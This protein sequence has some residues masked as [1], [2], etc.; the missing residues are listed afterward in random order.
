[1]TRATDTI[2]TWHHPHHIATHHTSYGTRYEFKPFTGDEPEPRIPD[3]VEAA[4]MAARDAHPYDSDTG[5]AVS[6]SSRAAYAEERAANTMWQ[7]ARHNR[8][9]IALIKQVAPLLA[10]MQQAKQAA[11]A[12]Y[13]ALHA[14]P[15]GFWQA[16]LLTITQLRKAALRAARQ[17]DAV[18]SGLAT[19][20]DGLPERVLAEI[21]AFAELEKAA[22][23]DL[24]DWYPRERYGYG[25][26][27]GPDEGELSKLFAEQNEHIKQ[28]TRLFSGEVN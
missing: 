28:A 6:A 18:A 15:D 25:Y 12:A 4:F 2:P 24:G 7:V 26:G 17:L 11:V 14:T 19:V 16:Q 10:T 1:M 21:P 8:D 9:T 20:A 22:G 5:R 13:E 23:T 27:V 3:N